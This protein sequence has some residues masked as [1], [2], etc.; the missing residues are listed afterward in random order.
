MTVANRYHVRPFEPADAPSLFAAVRASLPELAQ[1]MPWCT[2]DYS[3]EQADAWV[4]FT[5]QAWADRTEFPLAVVECA[6]GAVA[7]GTGIN[8][9]GWTHRIGN[10]GYWVSTPHRG[11][12]VARF[13]AK[14]A[15]AFGFG[16]LGLTRLEIVTLPHNIASQRVAESLGAVRECEARNRLVVHGVPHDALVYSLVPQDAAAWGGQL[17][18]AR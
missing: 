3:Q 16:E 15:A 6:S 13:A 17:A 8:Q 5:R 9:I 14:R 1:W 4:A 18:Y 10:I 7:G 12:G 11:R 2:P